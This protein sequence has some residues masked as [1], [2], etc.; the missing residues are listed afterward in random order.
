MS[1]VVN[2]FTP[3]AVFSIEEENIL[4]FRAGYIC[5]KV[6]R[7]ICEQCKQTL[8]GAL[9]VDDPTHTFIA[10][11]QYVDLK[12]EGL[13]VPSTHLMSV[14]TIIEKSFRGIVENVFHMNCIKARIVSA[15][16]NN[17]SERLTC[18]NSFISCLVTANGKA[19]VSQHP[20]RNQPVAIRAGCSQLRLV[21]KNVIPICRL[22]VN[23]IISSKVTAL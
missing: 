10:K 2:A 14:C 11:K 9:N 15:I 1:S 5:R 17:L 19:S 23:T 6:R 12:G 4:T 22:L 21:L 7:S 8:T 16:K 20:L 18:T 13:V 3:Q